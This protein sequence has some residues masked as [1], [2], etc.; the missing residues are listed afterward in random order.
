M[1]KGPYLELFYIVNVFLDTST[2][3]NDLKVYRFLVGLKFNNPVNTIKV[4]LSWSVYI[5]TLFLDKLSPLRTLCPLF[6]QKLTNA[7]L[8]SMEGRELPQKVYQD[9]FTRKNVAGRGGDQTRDLLIAIQKRIHLNLRGRHIN[10]FAYCIKGNH[11]SEI[12]SKHW[13]KLCLSV[14]ET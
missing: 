9:K 10:V 1:K 13:I 12:N 5:T 8:D 6:C 7:L 11:K 3:L 4:M 2:F 14:P